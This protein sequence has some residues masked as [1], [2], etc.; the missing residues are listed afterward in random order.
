[1]LAKTGGIVLVA[2]MALNVP[3]GAEKR[4]GIIGLDTSHS[5]AFTKLLNDAKKDPFFDGFRVTAAYPYGSLDIPS[6]TNRYPSYIKQMQD[7]EV[8]V[9]DSLDALFKETDVILLET[10]DGR[11]HLEQAIEVFKAGKPVF[12]DKPIA[13]SLADAIA[14]FQASEKYGVP[15]FSAS[16]LRYGKKT[17]EARAGVYGK[18]RAADAYTPCS[19]EPTH[20]GLTWY[21]IH[22]VELLY[23]V[24]GTGCVSVVSVREEN[25]DLVVGVWN[26]GRVTTLR[27]MRGKGAAYGCDVFAEKGGRMPL[28]GYEGYKPLLMEVITFFKTGEVPIA[29]AETIEMFAYMEAAEESRLQGGA[30]VTLAEMMT[31]AQEA[32]AKKSL[33]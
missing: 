31:K 10:N 30:S 32:V 12:I 4:V 28:S 33:K 11:R 15:T 9:V 27:G 3:C 20:P 18:I 24:M 7:M 2:C 5:I 8:K 16:A 23:T 17:Q 25:T 26:D 22:G 14:I 13:A 19:L 6:S 1:M 29:P 21:G